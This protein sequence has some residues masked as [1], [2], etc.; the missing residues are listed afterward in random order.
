MKAILF[1]LDGVLYNA[2]QPIP[3]AAEAVRVI[4]SRGIPHRFVTNTSTKSR[5]AL[6]S[7]LAR[8]G[9]ETNREH[10]FNPPYAAAQ[11]L[12]ERD[13][14]AV[15][16]FVLA[17]AAEEFVG[18]PL[19]SDDAERG[20]DYVVIGDMGERWDYYTLNRAFRLLHSDPH[21]TLVAL[22]M[23]RY[24]HGPDGLLLDVAPFVAALEHATERRAEVLGKP[25][26]PFF[27]T[28]LDDLRLAANEVVMI[29]DDVLGDVEAAQQVGLRGILVRTGKFQPADLDAGVTP[30]AVLNS[31]ADLPTWWDDQSGRGGPVRP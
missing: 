6:V 26:A 20:A 2:D 30:D 1:D 31:V 3:G 5:S 24:W 13:P 27:Q 29:G 15:A 22:G 21:A 8:Y 28:A 23:T 7:K 4:Q 12:W 9:V 25:A 18:L 14:K 19:L 16:L 10:I 11:W 17:S